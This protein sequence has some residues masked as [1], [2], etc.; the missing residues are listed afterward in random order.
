MAPDKNGTLSMFLIVLLLAC[1]TGVAGGQTKSDQTKAEI[2]VTDDFR[3]STMLADHDMIWNQFP[4]SWD[5][6]PFLGN[7][8]QGTLMYRTGSRKI[9]WDVGCSAAHDHR[10]AEKDDLSEKHV[11]VLNR[12]RH[13]IGHLEIDFPADLVGCK[14]KLSLW[15]AEATGVF[16]SSS[17]KANWKSFVH[18]TQP[19]MYFE[20][21][22]SGDLEGADFSYV[23]EKTLN[24]RAVRS[25][26]LRQPPHS[27]PKSGTAGKDMQTV[28]QQLVDGGQTA[29]AWRKT[30]T[31]NTIRLWLSVQHSHPGNEALPNAVAAVETACQA[32]QNT[33]IEKH[34]DWWHQYY[35]ASFVSTGDEFWDSFYWIQQYKLACATRDKGWIIDNQGPWLQPTAWASTWWN[36]NVQLSHQG[37]YAAN[38]RAMCSALSHRLDVNRD[39]LAL[40]VAQK[41]RLD[42]YAIG[43]T[44]SGWDL[45]GHAGEPGGRSEIPRNI[46][47]ETGNLMWALHNVDLE[48]RYW[49]DQELRDRVLFPLLVRAVNY[50]RH[51]LVQESDGNLHLGPTHSPELRN[52][53]DYTYDLDLLGWGVGRLLELADEKGLSEADQP[54][55]KIWQQLRDDLIPVH[56]DSSGRMIGKNAP[57]KAGT[58]TGRTCWLFI[59]CGR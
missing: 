6:G 20:L 32:D 41:Y 17:G 23:A 19:V 4:K 7:G 1:I 27:A 10:P 42:S 59:R 22:T 47:H 13:F 33:W 11:E 15:E 53:A 37:A 29:V 43:R 40:N 28:V 24:P 21:T 49:Q 39:N 31:G 55:I 57:L 56:T 58:G 2:Q 3:W 5:Q 54:L 26:S 30:K 36:L 12:G 25:K 9:R 46:A 44:A 45:L 35:P 50:Y 52:A 18:A 38:R 34:R 14:S 51:F 48:Y 8:E 16:S